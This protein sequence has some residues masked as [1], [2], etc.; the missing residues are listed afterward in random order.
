MRAVS[1]PFGN[2]NYISTAF[3][4]GYDLALWMHDYG[5]PS[6]SVN[7]VRNWKNFSIGVALLENISD[8]KAYIINIA[9]AANQENP[10]WACAFTHQITGNQF[11]F[12]EFTIMMN[13]ISDNFGAAGKD[14]VWVAS[15]EE[16]YDYLLV[17]SLL[18]INK[19]PEDNALII[20]LTGDYPEDLRWYASSLILSTDAKIDSISFEGTSFSSY[21]HYND[22][23]LIN[24]EWEGSGAPD[25]SKNAEKFIKI[26]ENVAVQ[27]E[28]MAL[29]ALDYTLQIRNQEIKNKLLRK[30]MDLNIE[31]V[32]SEIAK[33]IN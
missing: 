8:I 29:I 3:E 12:E 23:V 15:A 21:C 26:A 32:N 10:Q 14:N 9:D 24:V 7:T 1:L 11:S 5:V 31:K 18:K 20:S 28:C 22:R 33:F 27:K 25:P 4:S 13:Y 6:L 17:N 19:K 16:V 2:R 30:L